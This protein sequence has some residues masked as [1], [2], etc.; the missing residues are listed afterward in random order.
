MTAFAFS[1]VVKVALMPQEKHFFISVISFYFF[2]VTFELVYDLVKC[3][4]KSYYRFVLSFPDNC[5][6]Q[7]ATFINCLH[8]SMAGVYTAA[9]VYV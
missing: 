9:A 6:F 2:D 3:K 5:V 7:S 8:T 4:I 1:C